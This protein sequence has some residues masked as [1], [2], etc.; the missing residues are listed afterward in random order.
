[1]TLLLDTHALLWWLADDPAPT[2]ETAST[3]TFALDRA[4]RARAHHHHF[5]VSRHKGTTE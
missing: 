2:V 4:M 5:I 1:M 3:H